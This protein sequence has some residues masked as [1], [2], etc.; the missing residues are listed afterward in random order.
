MKEII[1]KELNK[2]L[3]RGDVGRGAFHIKVSII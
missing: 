2:Y 1:Q 3:M